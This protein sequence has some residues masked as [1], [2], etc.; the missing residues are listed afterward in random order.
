MGPFPIPHI[1][2]FS[3]WAHFCE[4]HQTLLA[5]PYGP[6][7]HRPHFNFLVHADFTIQEYLELDVQLENYFSGE[8]KALN[9]E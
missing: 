4:H 1:S 2:N 5:A 6:V 3:K 8:V 9:I 7:C